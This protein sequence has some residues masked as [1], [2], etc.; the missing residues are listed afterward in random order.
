MKR[1]RHLPAGMYFKHG[2]HWLVRRNKWHPLPVDL[3]PALAEYARLLNAPRA[4]MDESIDQALANAKARG[5]AENTLTQ[6]ASIAPRLKHIFAE[7]TPADVRPV[8]VRKMLNA[9]ADTPN[10]ANR[11][12]NLLVLAL[13][14]A[15]D[16]GEIDRNPAKEVEPLREAKRDRYITDEEFARIYDAAPPVV[17]IFMGL[18]YLTGQRIGDVLGIKHADL[19]E[20]GIAFRQQKT[21]ARLIIAWTPELRA[22][23]QRA[24]DLR[25][26]R[27][28]WLLCKRNGKPYSYKGMRDA[29]DRATIKASVADAT[30]HDLRAKSGTD[31]KKQGLNPTLLLGHSSERQ[32]KRYIR[33][34]LVDVVHGPTLKRGNG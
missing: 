18:A 12:R 33:Q 9:M 27:G 23:V 24:K 7:F 28:F 2:R 19:L 10:M 4:G 20:Q 13:Q 29:F 15:V 31:A 22:I 26:V 11:F 8:H 34:R 30:P 17:Q 14:A 32:T 5:L 21:D 25:Q 1:D 3:G 16:A 6:Y